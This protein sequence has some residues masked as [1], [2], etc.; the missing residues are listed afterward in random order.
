MMIN[1]VLL[2]APPKETIMVVSLDNIACAIE[3][4]IIIRARD[5]NE[6]VNFLLISYIIIP[7]I[8]TITDSI[9][10]L[11]VRSINLTICT[12]TNLIPSEVSELLESHT[13]RNTNVVIN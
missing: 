9:L 6:G 1:L 8:L 4:D 3:D 11:L 12:I 7:T 10:Y 2:P 5:L 13:T